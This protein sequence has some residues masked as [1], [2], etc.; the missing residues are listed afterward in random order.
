MDL[1]KIR[2]DASPLT[3]RI[4]IARVGKDGTV[5]LDTRDA[6]GECIGA[7]IE[8]V[9]HKAPKGATLNVTRGDGMAYELTVKP[10]DAAT[11]AA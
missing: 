1:K 11:P 4:R 7:V 6:T 3:N 9:L 2:I 5:A 10:V 8:H